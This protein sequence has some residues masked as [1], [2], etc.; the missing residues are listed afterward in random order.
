VCVCVCVYVCVYV[1]V[2]VFIINKELIL[3]VAHM[4]L[5]N[6]PKITTI[7]PVSMLAVL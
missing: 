1:C 5:N 2:C 4:N 6:L 7:K 3:F